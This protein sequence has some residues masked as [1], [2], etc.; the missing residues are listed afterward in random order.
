MSRFCLPILGISIGHLFRK[1][2]RSGRLYP[3]SLAGWFA[4]NHFTQSGTYEAVTERLWS[5]RNLFT[6]R[7]R[8]RRRKWHG[9]PACVCSY[10]G[11]KGR[12]E[13]RRDACSTF[14]EGRRPDV[15]LHSGTSQFRSLATSQLRCSSGGQTGL[16]MV[17]YACGNIKR[18]GDCVVVHGCLAPREPAR[19]GVNSC[20]A[21]VR[22]GT[23]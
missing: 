7:L 16:F 5:A 20:G 15:H 12:G 4:A 22:S 19:C 3:A 14:P 1:A 8:S 9:R 6:A 17:Y 21:P 2:V 10:R 18:A 11:R 13:H 23:S